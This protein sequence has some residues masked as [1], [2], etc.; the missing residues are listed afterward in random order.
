MKYEPVIRSSVTTYTA[1]F[2]F[3]QLFSPNSA[4]CLNMNIVFVVD[5]SGSMSGSTK[6]EP[7]K[8]FLRDAISTLDPENYFNI[9]SARDET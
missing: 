7:V 3:M 8:Q 5:V 2:R 1:N 6:I 9:I 4:T